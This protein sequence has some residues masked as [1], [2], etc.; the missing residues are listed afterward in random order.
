MQKI[1]EKMSNASPIAYMGI[2]GVDVPKE[3]SEELGIPVGAYVEEVEMESPAMR[4]GIQRG[5]VIVSV[6]DKAVSGFNSYSNSLLLMEP[7]QTVNVTIMR[8]AQEEYKEME[9]SIELG[10][11]E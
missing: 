1:V 3:A 4:A 8:Q 9:F 7:G 5:D 6:D 10:G 2:K 11:V